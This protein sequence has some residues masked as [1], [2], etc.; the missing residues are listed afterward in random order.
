MTTVKILYRATDARGERITTI[1]RGA[2]DPA[3]LPLTSC[4]LTVVNILSI[5]S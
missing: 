1:A 4:L 3:V 5:N 2:D